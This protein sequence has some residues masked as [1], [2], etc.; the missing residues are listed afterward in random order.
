[1]VSDKQIIEAAILVFA[2]KPDAT[3]KEVAKEAGVTR[4]TINR[5]FGSK[6]DLLKLAGRHCLERFN[7]VLK[8]AYAA[9]RPAIE[10]IHM[11]LY[12]SA[13]LRNHHFFWMRTFVDDQQRN[14]ELFLKRL[15]VVEKL[16][17]AAQQAGDIRSELP[18]GWVAS[19]LDHMAVAADFSL[20]RGVVAESDVYRMAWDTLLNGIAP[21]K[22]F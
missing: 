9:D 1:M 3:M 7:D 19:I 12:G 15:D 20:K 21:K 2:N 8:S 18:S 16:V 11:I 10:K 13:K 22:F 4:I 17:I 14:Q 5:K 6:N